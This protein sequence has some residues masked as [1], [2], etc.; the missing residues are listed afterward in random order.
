MN[1]PVAAP[2][3]IN[4][5]IGLESNSLVFLPRFGS[6]TLS[7]PRTSSRD[8]KTKPSS[9]RSIAAAIPSAKSPPDPSPASSSSPPYAP[10]FK[11]AID[12]LLLELL[13]SVRH[14]P[15]LFREVHPPHIPGRPNQIDVHI[16]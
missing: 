12:A 6:C 15:I 16:T 3:R 7:S 1:S 11:P 8:A 13:H 14:H 9:S 4:I 5:K 2:P 10:S